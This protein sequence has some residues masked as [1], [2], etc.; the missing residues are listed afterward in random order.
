MYTQDKMARNLGVGNVGE[1]FFRHWFETNIIP[2]NPRVSLRQFGYNPDGIVVGHEKVEMLKSLRESPDFAVFDSTSGEDGKL[3]AGVSVNTQH[4][5]FTMQQARAPWLCWT[6]GRK[7]QQE[8]FDKKIGNLWYNE[9]NIIN[10]YR[11]FVD[12]FGSEVLLV[13][14]VATWFKTVYDKTVEEHLEAAALR[15]IKS[16]MPAAGASEDQELTR[17]MDLL[18]RMGGRSKGAPRKFELLWIPYS[19][20]RSGHIPHS[21]AGA[22]VSRGLPRRVVCIDGKSA[23]KEDGFAPFV[24]SLVSH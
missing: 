16:G 4:S 13:T 2:K 21:I 23:Q 24:A 10:D 15:Y 18:L 17:F 22:P 6:C 9:Y 3:L 8:C 5:L 11:G 20:V 7:V 12:L 1:A 14:I 19:E